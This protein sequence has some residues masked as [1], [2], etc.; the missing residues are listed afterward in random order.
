M[1]MSE[2]KPHC[3]MDESGRVIYGKSKGYFALFT[4]GQLKA[5]QEKSILDLMQ[6][7]VGFTKA[8]KHI[9]LSEVLQ[10]LP[11]TEN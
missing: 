6:K 2:Q 9:P 3:Y 5:E 4:A 11:T 8:G 1:N 7:G 10:L